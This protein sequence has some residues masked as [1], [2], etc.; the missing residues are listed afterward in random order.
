MKSKL[1]AVAAKKKRI[2]CRFGS[3]NSGRVELQV[4]LEVGTHQRSECTLCSAA[5]P[6][7]KSKSLAV[8]LYYS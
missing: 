6:T 7:S 4:D 8:T 1:L 2:L 3:W 5:T